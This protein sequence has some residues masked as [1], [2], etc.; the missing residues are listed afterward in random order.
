MNPYGE[1]VLNRIE[2]SMVDDTFDYNFT[3]S[4]AG[5]NLIRSTSE[6]KKES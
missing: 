1:V 2:N 3:A 6:D 5:Y 4:N